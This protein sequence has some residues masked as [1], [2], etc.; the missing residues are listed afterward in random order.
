MELHI[1]LDFSIRI[2]WYMKIPT[3]MEL[4]IDLECPQGPGDI[5]I[6][7]PMELHIDLDCPQGS[8]DIQIPTPMELHIDLECPQGSDDIQE[9]SEITLWNGIETVWPR[10]LWVEDCLL[11]S[12]SCCFITWCIKWLWSWR[13]KFPNVS[14]GFRTFVSESGCFSFRSWVSESACPLVSE[15]ACLLV[16]E[17]AVLVSES[18]RDRCT[19]PGSA[20]KSLPDLLQN[21]LGNPVEPDLALH[22]S[23][24]DLL[25]NV[26][27]LL[28]NLV[29]PDPGAAP[30]HT[31]A[32]LGWRPH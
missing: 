15:S 2:R 4:H 32:V 5:K 12:M 26:R 30:V 20:P 23:L 16:S 28:Q 17:S 22:Q 25:R 27:N 18:A 7:T 19:W 9:T 1:D 8:D 11:I 3:P 6:P 24:P 31:G 29:E 10:D 13:F 21:L 14:F